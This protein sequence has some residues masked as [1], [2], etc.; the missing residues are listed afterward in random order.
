M[1]LSDTKN[2]LK[3]MGYSNS[4]II[5]FSEQIEHFEIEAP[6]RDNIVKSYLNEKCI[7]LIVEEILNE[8]DDEV[9]L[10][11]VAAGSGFFTEKIIEK[12]KK[13]K[14]YAIDI[15]PSML[16]ILK[17]KN[18]NSIWGI[19][20]RISD[21]ISF[22]NEY[23]NLDYPIK[24]DFIMSTLAF[25]HFTDPKKVLKS[26]HDVKKKNGKI[27]IIDILKHEYND[28]L[29]DMKDTHSGFSINELKE[30]SNDIF[31]TISIT[32]LNAYCVVEDKKI[33][34]YKAIFK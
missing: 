29:D 32:P 21:S 14:P 7:N 3:K 12:Q 9:M 8:I 1:D 33:Y 13:I 5:K 24:Y 2:I 10:L 27:V 31:N 30:L 17:N 11:D 16:D 6:N 25:H 26:M 15:T 22:F 23:Y 18:I 19:A 34:L 20:E 28:I 4:E